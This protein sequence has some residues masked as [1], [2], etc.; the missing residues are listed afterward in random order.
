MRHQSM[1][2]KFAK[3]VAKMLKDAGGVMITDNERYIDFTL[4]TIYGYLKVNVPK[5]KSAICTIYARFV[6]V[7]LAK[8]GLAHRSNFNVYSGKYNIHEYQENLAI[9]ALKRDI[10]SLIKV[11]D[12][13]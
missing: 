11:E 4:N 7:D 8:T 5:E 3:A 6:D 9:D 1:K 12:L 2:V 13:E 10:L